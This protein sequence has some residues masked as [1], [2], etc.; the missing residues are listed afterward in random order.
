[1]SDLP[2]SF[3]SPLDS[4]EGAKGKKIVRNRTVPSAEPPRSPQALRKYSSVRSS[5]PEDDKQ[6]RSFLRHP[7]Q[8]EKG[9]EPT[10]IPQIQVVVDA[11]D[12]NGQESVGTNKNAVF[13]TP[14]A[15]NAESPPPDVGVYLSPSGG[16]ARTDTDQRMTFSYDPFTDGSAGSGHE[17][18]HFAKSADY[19]SSD[20][21]TQ[22]K[23]KYV[24]D[25]QSSTHKSSVKRWTESLRLRFS[26]GGGRRRSKRKGQVAWEEMGDDLDTPYQLNV[27]NPRRKVEGG[28]HVRT[29]GSS[30]VSATTSPLPDKVEE[31]IQRVSRRRD[32]VTVTIQDPGPEGFLYDRH[33]QKLEE[34]FCANHLFGRQSD[35]VDEGMLEVVEQAQVMGT[36]THHH[37]NYRKT[38]VY[39]RAYIIG[40]LLS[41]WYIFWI[42]ESFESVKCTLLI[43][44]ASYSI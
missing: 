10:S 18:G 38:W 42:I 21:M 32:T 31:E 5:V 40:T 8:G 15:V 28:G 43:E 33:I 3:S 22:H 12:T 35:N 4:N 29:I 1:M 41:Q 16:G 27:G 44:N 17:I 25:S 9:V 36:N 24:T 11:A 7:T 13:G 39:S 20:M 14:L 34:N 6:E 37:G 19:Q 2:P 26:S 23:H 30:S